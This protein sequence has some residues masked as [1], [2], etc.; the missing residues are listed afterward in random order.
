MIDNKDI[1]YEFINRQLIDYNDTSKE[2]INLVL[3]NEA[4]EHIV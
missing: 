3:F 1:L 2:K 4:L